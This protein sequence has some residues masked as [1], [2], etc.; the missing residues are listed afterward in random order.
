ME[1]IKVN[2]D[3]KLGKMKPMH[4]V[5]NGPVHKFDTDMAVS[6]FEAY[7]AAGIPYARNHDANHYSTYGGPHTVDTYAIFPN[8]DADPYDEN[9]YDFACTD[10][11]L[12]VIDAAGTKIFYRLGVSI[13]HY[14][15]KYYAK[16]PKDFEKWAIICEHIIKHYVYGWANGFHYD[17][18]YWEIWNE[19][20]NNN[21]SL[22]WGGT[23]EQFYVFFNT[24]YKHLKAAFPEL[25]FG[26]PSAAMGIWNKQWLEGFFDSLQMKPDFFSWHI[27]ARDVETVT[28]HIRKYRKWLDER[29]FTETESILNE[30]NYVCGW[31]KEDWLYSKRII[32]NMKGAAF[33]AGVISASQ[34]EDID[35]LMYYDARPCGMCGMFDTDFVCDTLKGYYPFKMFNEVY[36][37]DNAVEV[38]TIENVYS[39]A[40]TNGDKSAVMATYFDD[41]LSNGKKE[42]L[43]TLNGLIKEKTAEIYLLDDTHDMELIKTVKVTN[44]LKLNMELYSSVLIKIL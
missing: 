21:V 43:F 13:E 32:K 30:W 22:T 33:I 38:E 34:Y 5:N 36:S 18:E 31:E 12:R 8:F 10:E 24:A 40:A 29:G 39:V 23:S 4:A 3:K 9:N 44:A 20:D 37:L 6:N 42:I 11:Y 26:G 7:K 2:F 16:P 35:M 15:K 25:K 14:I 17:I 1:Q 41:N 27:Y 19:P 28:D